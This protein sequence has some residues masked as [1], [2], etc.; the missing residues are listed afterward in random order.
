MF[1][2]GKNLNNKNPL[3]FAQALDS[4]LYWRLFP[5][6]R[7]TI[8]YVDIETTGLSKDYNEITTIALYDGKDVHTYVNGKNLMQFKTD[9]QKYKMI[10]TYNGRAF[11]VPF[12]ERFFSI[13]LDHAHIDLRYLLQRL[14]QTGGLKAIEQRLGIDRGAL[15]SVDGFFAVTLWHEYKRKQ[16]IKALETLLAYNCADVVNL[17]HLLIYVFNKNLEST[18]FSHQKI[19]YNSMPIIIPF[20][21]DSKLLD[22]LT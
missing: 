1:A 16:N 20:Q 22:R 19:M 11:D 15:R 9:I 8:A 2:H 13:K 10:V 7:D 17:E 14:G 4:D 5:D 6:F 12:I 3:F 18:P 21:A